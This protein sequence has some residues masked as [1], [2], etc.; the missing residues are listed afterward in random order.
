MNKL[1]RELLSKGSVEN[2]DFTNSYLQAHETMDEEEVS[3]L[4]D[5]CQ[6]AF[7][8]VVGVG[9]LQRNPPATELASLWFSVALP[10]TLLLLEVKLAGLTNLSA[11]RCSI[12][13][14][15][16]STIKSQLS[17]SHMLQVGQDEPV[18]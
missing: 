16:S 13:I 10:K 3:S 7:V 8:V 11:P 5:I 17:H 1:R 12:S 4:V 2:Y 6:D 18:F 9:T 14:S 15:A